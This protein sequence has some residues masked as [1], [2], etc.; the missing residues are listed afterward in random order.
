MNDQEKQD[1]EILRAAIRREKESTFDFLRTL[2]RATGH[3]LLTMGYR[4]MTNAEAMRR[5]YHNSQARIEKLTQAHVR[6][7]P[8]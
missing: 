8:D 3:D 6:K 5:A 1:L 4:G 2:D 7:Y